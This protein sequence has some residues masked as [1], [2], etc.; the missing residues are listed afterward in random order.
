M[1]AVG[2]ITI[3]MLGGMI[4]IQSCGAEIEPSAEKL[5]LEKIAGSW[6]LDK[7]DLDGVDVTNSFSGMVVVIGEDKSFTVT[8]AVP[9]MWKSASAFALTVTGNSF[10]VHRDDGLIIDVRQVTESHLILEF[11]YDAIMMGGRA[12]SL[13]GE[14][15]FEFNAN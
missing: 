11:H 4:F 13:T 5:F 3:L 15:T 14:F 7:A 8:N 6:Q 10:Q 9:P 2:C 12:A 1:K